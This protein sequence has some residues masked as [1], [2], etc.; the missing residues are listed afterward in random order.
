MNPWTANAKVVRFN[1]ETF[2]I[3]DTLDVAVGPDDTDS[4][5]TGTGSGIGSGSGTGTGSGSENTHRVQI[6][7]GFVQ[8]TNGYLVLNVDKPS[9]Q[10]PYQYN[11]GYQ[12]KGTRSLVRSGVN[13]SH[14]TAN[15]AHAHH[16]VIFLTNP[17]LRAR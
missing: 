2:T 16:N 11:Y 13:Y 1:T 5:G 9:N 4:G 7:D 8:G 14:A 12:S 3:V 17:P 6:F 15:S 10:D